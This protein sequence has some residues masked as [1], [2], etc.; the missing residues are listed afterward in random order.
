MWYAILSEDVE[1]SNDKRAAARPAHIDRR[2][3]SCDQQ[4][5]FGGEFL[6]SIDKCRPCSGTLVAAVLDVF[7]HDRVPHQAC[8]SL[9]AGSPWL[10]FHAIQKTCAVIKTSMIPIEPN[11]L[12]LAQNSRL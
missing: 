10:I 8:S 3:R 9:S 12:K 4:S 2:V 5:A 11:T 1:D 6:Q 7:T